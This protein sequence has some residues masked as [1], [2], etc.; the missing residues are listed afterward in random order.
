M[1]MSLQVAWPISV[2]SDGSPRYNWTVPVRLPGIT[3]STVLP[4]GFGHPHA[5]EEARRIAEEGIILR[6]QVGSGGHGT[7]VCGQDNRDDM[8]RCLEPP[9][10]VTHLPSVSDSIS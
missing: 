5:S 1:R 9:T 4:A 8:G 3:G 6:V 2:A 10:S 7:P